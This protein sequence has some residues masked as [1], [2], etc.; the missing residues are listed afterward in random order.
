MNEHPTYNLAVIGYGPTGATPAN[1][2]GRLGLNAASLLHRENVRAVAGA[3]I[4][5]H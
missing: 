5:G 4:P 2:L 3:G 1:P